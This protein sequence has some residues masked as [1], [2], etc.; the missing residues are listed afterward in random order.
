MDV[1]RLPRKKPRKAEGEATAKAEGD[2]TA[3]AKAE[4]DF[5]VLS[6][7][8]DDW[9]KS[10]AT[11]LTSTELRQREKETEE[12]LSGTWERFRDYWFCGII[13]F[14]DVSK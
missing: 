1:E 10:V 2:G 6:A 7:E 5:S 8:F 12:L 14:D 9:R 3:M 4:V 11:P 13:P